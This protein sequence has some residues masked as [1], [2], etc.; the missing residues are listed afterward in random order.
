MD[1]NALLGGSPLRMVRL[2]DSGATFVREGRSPGSDGERALVRRLS[3]AGLVHTVGGRGPFTADDVTVVVPVHADP[4]GLAATVAAEPGALVVDDT[5]GRGP[6]WA[7]NRGWRATATPVVAFLDAGCVPGPGWLDALLPHLADDHV[8][9]VAPRVVSAPGSST[10]A[11]YEHSRSPLD[12]GRRPGPVRPGSWVPYVPTA[13]LVVRREALE[14]MDGFDES[15]RYGEDV[16]LVWRLAR[17]GHHV[18]YEPAAEVVHPPRRNLAG[19]LA[20]RYRYGTS[21]A[22][23]AERHGAAVAPLSVSGWTAAAWGLVAAGGPAAGVAVAAASSAP[24]LRRLPAIEVA[25]VAGGG[26][27]RAGVRLAEAA[28][29]TWWPLTL[30]TLLLSR[31]ARRLAP[32]VTI[33]LVADWVADG[34][35]VPLPAYAGLRLADDMAY[36][37]GVWAGALRARSGRALV[38]IVT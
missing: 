17:A 28:R 23:L 1:R 16:D 33:P 19:W 35:P 9:A 21:A 8:V 20:Q 7:R 26:H 37:A 3:D 6:A 25:R 31:R 22:P 18:R 4:A 38:P 32:L 13:A 5:D 24:L 29:R 2:T 15:L 11:R 14:A 30:A 27:L 34:R 36:G 10:I 12:R